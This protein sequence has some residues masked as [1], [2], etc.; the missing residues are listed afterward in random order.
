LLVAGRLH[1][2]AGPAR[3]KEIHSPF[4]RWEKGRGGAFQI[5]VRCPFEIIKNPVPNETAFL[6]QPA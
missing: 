3:V 6:W 5:L 1:D 4:P 2:A